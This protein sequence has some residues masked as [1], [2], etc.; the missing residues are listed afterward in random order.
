[1]HGLL[2]QVINNLLIYILIKSMYAS[3]ICIFLMQTILRLIVS[4][5]VYKFLELFSHIVVA[6]YI[7]SIILRKTV[8]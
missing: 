5:I 7:I 8:C 3:L 4:H 6:L 2:L 1:M